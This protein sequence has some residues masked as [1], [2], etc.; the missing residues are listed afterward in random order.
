LA[1]VIEFVGTI[2]EQLVLPNWSAD[3]TAN[4]I[5]IE[6]A[7]AQPSRFLLVVWS[8]VGAIDVVEPR[9]KMQLISS[10]LGDDVELAASPASIPRCKYLQLD[11]EFLHGV[12]ILL[13]TGGDAGSLL[14]V[15]SML[16]LFRGRGAAH[17][18]A[19]TGRAAQL[20]GGVG[21][22]CRKVQN[23]KKSASRDG[24]V[25][26]RFAIKGAA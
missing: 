11:D 24:N 8:V 4:A 7:L 13:S 6:A 19:H 2:K 20:G 9:T 15:P 26:N 5:E 1:Q 14:S 12:R 17:G 10:C 23:G 22:K 21:Q 25:G 16:K 18:A 3:I